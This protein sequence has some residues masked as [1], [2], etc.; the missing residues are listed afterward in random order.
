LNVLPEPLAVFALTGV[1]LSQHRNRATEKQ[2]WEEGF[3]APFRFVGPFVRLHH[4][5]CKWRAGAY[6]PFV[7]DLKYYRSDDLQHRTTFTHLTLGYTWPR[8][9]A[10]GSG[11]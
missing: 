11:N 2:R 9:E 1:N 4:W 3:S 6:R 7:G 10:G 8:I 5:W